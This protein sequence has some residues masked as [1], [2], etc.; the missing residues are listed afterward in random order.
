MK[1]RLPQQMEDV[2]PA[3]GDTFGA[4]HALLCHIIVVFVCCLPSLSPEGGSSIFMQEERSI[5]DV[6]VRRCKTAALELVSVCHLLQCEIA[7]R[8]EVRVP[9]PA[10]VTAVNEGDCSW[11]GDTWQSRPIVF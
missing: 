7:P 2:V 1:R 9:R 11:C 5:D 10:R 8:A 4:N 3:S 6:D